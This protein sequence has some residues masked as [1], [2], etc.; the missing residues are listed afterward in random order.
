[1]LLIYFKLINKSFDNNKILCN[2]EN[3]IIAGQSEVKG[4]QNEV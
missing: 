4:S 2:F 1:L 3:E